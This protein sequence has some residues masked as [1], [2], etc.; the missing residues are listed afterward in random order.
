M[1]DLFNLAAIMRVEELA[2]LLVAEDFRPDSYD[3]L[4]RGKNESYVLGIDRG[5]WSVFYRERDKEND[6]RMFT[7]ESLAC[8]DL[9]ARLRS[10]RT[11]RQR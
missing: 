2:V 7:D 4:G 11:T 5:M 3:P 1:T 8:A 6:K 10:D 9:M